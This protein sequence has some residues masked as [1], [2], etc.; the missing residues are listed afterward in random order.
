[1]AA[2]PMAMVA[3]MNH[4]PSRV[5]QM[6]RGSQGRLAGG[7]GAETPERDGAPR[8]R[9]VAAGGRMDDSHPDS[10]RRKDPARKIPAADRVIS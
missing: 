2:R 1:M 7:R 6:V 5:G 3:P 9:A 8:G 10:R 4:Q